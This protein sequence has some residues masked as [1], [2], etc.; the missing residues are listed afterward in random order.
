MVA[1]AAMAGDKRRQKQDPAQKEPKK[2]KATSTL[3][4]DQANEAATKQ[5]AIAAFL[6]CFAAGASTMSTTA[7]SANGE[8]DQQGGNEQAPEQA[9][10][11]APEQADSEM[12]E[13][14]QLCGS[15]ENRSVAA[16][17]AAAAEEG[18]A[19][20]APEG[21]DGNCGAGRC[22]WWKAAAAVEGCNIVW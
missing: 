6:G 4:P 5:K 21:A 1:M 14:L 13:T 18:D 9:H 17:V 2:Q 7:G 12:G 22:G 10:E 8:E 19:A 3:M 16:S 11:Q 15:Q 20:P